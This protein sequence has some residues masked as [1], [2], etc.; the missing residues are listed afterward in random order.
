[1]IRH[2]LVHLSL[3]IL[4]LKTARIFWACFLCSDRLVHHNLSCHNHRVR[5]PTDLGG[6]FDGILQPS[7]ESYARAVR[8]ED[9]SA[10]LEVKATT[11]SAPAI[12]N[13]T[14]KPNKLTPAKQANG[15]ARGTKKRAGT[16][17]SPLPPNSTL[18][19]PVSRA[20]YFSLSVSLIN[21]R[22]DA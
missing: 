5:R 1:M 18:D 2:T 20:I 9:R 16:V 13:T 22:S 19:Q 3:P 7:L 15:S 4:F 14:R 17:A 8:P 21:S 10:E 12:A 6:S 11:W